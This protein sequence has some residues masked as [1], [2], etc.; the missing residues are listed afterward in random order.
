M[1]ELAVV[2]QRLGRIFTECDKNGDGVVNK[3]ELIRACREHPEVASFWGVSSQI[4]QEDGSRDTLERKFQEM[5]SNDD[6]TLSWTEFLNHHLQHART[7][8]AAPVRS[9][10][11]GGHSS[12][13]S[14]S[15]WAAMQPSQS[16]C[17]GALPGGASSVGVL[18][19]TSYVAGSGMSSLVLRSAVVLPQPS[20]TACSQSSAALPQFPS[21]HVLPPTAARVQGSARVVQRGAHIVSQRPSGSMP[22]V[23]LPMSPTANGTIM[24][25]SSMNSMP[26]MS[27]YGTSAS[28]QGGAG[29]V[30]AG[31]R[32]GRL[33]APLVSSIPAAVPAASNPALGHSH[34]H[35]GR[36]TTPVRGHV[37]PLVDGTPKPSVVREESSE[38][39]DEDDSG[40][41]DEGRKG[42]IK[43][44][45][46]GVRNFAEDVKEGWHELVRPDSQTAVVKKKPPTA[47]RGAALAHAPAPSAAHH[48]Q[49]LHHQQ[50]QHHQQQL[51]VMEQQQQQQQQEYQEYQLQM[52]R[53][54]EEQMAA[55][56]QQQQQHQRQMEQY[57][58]QQQ[59]LHLTSQLEMHLSACGHAPPTGPPFGS[60]AALL[61]P[62]LPPSTS[63]PSLAPLPSGPWG[64]GGYPGLDVYGGVPPMGSFPGGPWV[65]MPSM[66]PPSSGALSPPPAD[67]AWSSMPP[68][69]HSGMPDPLL[70]SWGATSS[71]HLPPPRADHYGGGGGFPGGHSSPP[72]AGGH[73]PMS[74]HLP[75]P[76]AGA[77]SPWGSMP[78]PLAPGSL[79]AIPMPVGSFH[80]GG[81]GGAPLSSGTYVSAF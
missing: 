74:G 7:K 13:G 65:S 32:S 19:Y 77:M 42:A 61:P 35:S 70:A 17:S 18:R 38:G 2:V 29:V 36:P 78:P 58:L 55:Q 10:T 25:P 24:V 53:Q 66:P 76:S 46:R 51:K 75:P 57:Q 9:I 50:G 40:S 27:S 34:S 64:Y 39:E 67:R 45:A 71:G 49:Q 52:Q 11:D 81:Y 31:V 22:T 59:Q 12:A 21:T 79:G 20:F 54:Y 15:G 33:S 23:Q 8:V 30:V 3:R 72:A 60:S 47:T 63:F 73:L 68:Q 56:L 41:G 1:S 69:L 26:S 16:A 62:P 4:R 28:L 14:A 5:D 80:M 44:F 48:Q 37:N 6:R 43:Y